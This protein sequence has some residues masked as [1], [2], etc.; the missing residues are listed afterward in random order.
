MVCVELSLKAI[1]N[2]IFKLFCR[3][4]VQ[5]CTPPVQSFLSSFLKLYE[6]IILFGILFCSVKS[7]HIKMLYVARLCT[8]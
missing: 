5:K 3:A 4:A 2:D 8:Y 7:N 6:T 1:K